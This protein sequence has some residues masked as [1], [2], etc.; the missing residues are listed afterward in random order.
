MGK[1]HPIRKY[2][3]KLDAELSIW[4]SGLFGDLNLSCDSFTRK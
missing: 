1:N 3:S 2:G 4:F